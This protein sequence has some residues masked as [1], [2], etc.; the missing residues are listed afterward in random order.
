[1]RDGL[2]QP[3][4]GDA[5]WLLLAHELLDRGRI[6]P[7]YRERLRALAGDG[8]HSS[9]GVL[10]LRPAATGF[11]PEAL[12]TAAGAGDWTRLE[13]AAAPLA[14]ALARQRPRRERM[15]TTGRAVA[16][17]TRR[18]ARRPGRRGANLALL[19]PNGV[20][21]ST[22]A[23][24]LRRAVPLETRVVHMG[25]WKASGGPA[26]R[27]AAEVA[28]R[29]LS[30]LSRYAGARAHELAG[31]IVLFDRYVHEARLPAQPPF[32]ALKRPYQGLLGR[33]VPSPD[34]TV[35]LDIAG[36]LAY[37]R[38]QE[39][40]PEELEAERRFYGGLPGVEVVDASLDADAVRAAVATVL[41]RTLVR[42]WA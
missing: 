23:D 3:R 31:R 2:A 16:G 21:K 22:V 10:L 8:A 13:T 41:W 25:I 5:F 17:A 36:A 4:S 40:P 11:P 34:A 1:V 19:G 14:A 38:K 35:A 12:T 15:A 27:R 42:R 26:P 37:E 20:G 39:N 33:V 30:L 32:R 24:G 9:L 29:P 18:V 7:R 28:L 6:D